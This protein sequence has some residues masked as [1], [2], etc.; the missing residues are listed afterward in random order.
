MQPL[1]Y[2]S[3][4]HQIIVEKFFANQAIAIVKPIADYRHCLYQSELLLVQDVSE[5][6]ILEFSTGRDCAHQALH[7]LGFEACPILIGPHREP[8]WPE[9]IVGS[10]SHCR[11]LAGVVVANNGELKSVGFDI[12]NIR[13]LNP[14]IARHVCTESEKRWLMLQD[15]DKQNLSLLLIF[16]LKEA[17]FKCIYHITRHRLRFQEC[18]VIPSFHENRAEAIINI[19]DLTLENFELRLA[20]YVNNT[21]IYS[22]AMLSLL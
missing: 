10:I 4:R 3:A 21:H 17:I 7:Q 1:P 8:I 22:G 11:D 6:R 14:N 5:K 13:H 2:D 12:E 16:S 20:F 9:P 15:T 18:Q 19:P